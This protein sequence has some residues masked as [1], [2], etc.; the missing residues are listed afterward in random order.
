MIGSEKLRR[1]KFIKLTLFGA[2][3]AWF[4]SCRVKN[5]H[6]QTTKKEINTVDRKT[7]ST[8]LNTARPTFKLYKKGD[9]EYDILR[10]GFNKR[11]NK[12]PAFIALCTTTAEVAQAVS[13]GIK[14][15]MPV[16]IKSG[17]HCF[18]G[19]SCN[20][21][22]LVINLSLMN[23]VE[24]VNDSEINVGAGCRIADLYNS[25]LPKNKLLPAGSCAGVGLAGL[26]LGGGYGIFSREYGLTC[27]NLTEITMVDGKG[28]I[29]QSK[30]NDELLW[31]CKGGGNGNF[32]VITSMKFSLQPSPSFLQ[33]HRFT[34]KNIDTARAVNVLEK[35]FS[36][37]ANMPLHCFSAFVLNENSLYLL[38]T[39]TKEITPD[40]QKIIHDISSI[41]DETTAGERIPLQRAIKAFYGVRQPLY[42]KNASAGFY[43]D[44]T[45]IEK[46]IE[47]VIDKV[48]HT[49]GMIYQVNTL[50]GKINDKEF[51]EQSSYAHRDKN[52]LSELQT[53]WQSPSLTSRT[54]AAFEEVQK[55]FYDNGLR[56]QYRNYPDINLHKWESAYFDKSYPGLQKIKSKYD[57]ENIFRF[58]QSVQF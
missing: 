25:I 46:C 5:I 36:I 47:A 33:S 48:I 39:N 10:R 45:D 55:I 19:F 38:L 53:Y 54:V 22:G 57:P 41:T 13:F 9:A 42:F 16:S 6:T 28:N 11:I 44:Y 52:Y 34:I 18:E 51:A 35:W 27:D 37:T 43:K 3:A 15:K 58:E 21:D 56:A 17:G 24:W 23:K 26:T 50:G 8:S 30:N 32:G 1:K 14:N 4:S 7:D 29:V 2:A 20:N 49:K 40:L 12:F 31:A